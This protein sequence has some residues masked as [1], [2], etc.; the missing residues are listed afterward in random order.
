MF[1]LGTGCINISSTQPTE[2]GCPSNTTY[3]RISEHWP[4]QFKITPTTPTFTWFYAAAGGEPGSVDAWAEECVPES[5]SLHLSSGP[6]FTD[7]IV[8]Q[9]TNPS[10]VPDPTKLTMEWSLSTPLDPLKTYRWFIVGHAGGI[11]IGADRLPKL[12]LHDWWPPLSTYYRSVFRTGPE[13]SGSQIDVPT[14]ITPAGG[15]II[16][17]LNPVLHWEVSSCMPLVFVVEISTTPNFEDPQWYV[18]PSIPGDYTDMTQT[19]APVLN[20]E[21]I[22]RDC[23]QYFWR[24][25][26]GIGQGHA[27]DPRV[28]GAYSDTHSFTVSSSSCPAP[29]PTQP[30]NCTDLSESACVENSQCEWVSGLT[31]FPHCTDKP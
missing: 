20:V 30:V 15:E 23:T 6:D 18:D 9:I 10:V 8:F 14:L 1:I 19:D 2:T 31:H 12:H 3:G 11:D 13:C 4:A 24:V 16:Q 28:W 27:G 5:Y 7:E 17:T 25:K 21:Y 22:L 26:G 29:T